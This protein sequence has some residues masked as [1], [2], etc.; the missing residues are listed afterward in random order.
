MALTPAAAPRSVTI[1]RY[2]H[3]RPHAI[4]D[5][6]SLEGD[7]VDGRWGSLVVLGRSIDRRYLAYA[8]TLTAIV[9]L[10]GQATLR[11]SP[12]WHACAG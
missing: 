11:Y 9:V 10:I 7:W 1:R 8:S 12:A 3:V 6:V 5:R 2:R 4:G